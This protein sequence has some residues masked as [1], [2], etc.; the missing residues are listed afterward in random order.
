MVAVELYIPRSMDAAARAEAEASGVS[1]AE[2]CRRWLERGRGAVKR[3]RKPIRE[4]S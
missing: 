3:A 4:Q 1:V 2:V